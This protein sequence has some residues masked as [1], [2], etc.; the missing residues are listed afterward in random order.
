MARAPGDSHP[1]GRPAGTSR[2]LPLPFSGGPQAGMNAGT[3]SSPG[4]GLAR[5]TV[6]LIAV[7]FLLGSQMGFLVQFVGLLACFH[8]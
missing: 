2:W 8:H 1:S 7:F 4:R 6:W 3:V 5:A